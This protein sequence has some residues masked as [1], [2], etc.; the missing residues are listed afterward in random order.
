MLR[1]LCCK[2][3]AKAGSREHEVFVHWNLFKQLVQNLGFAGD[4]GDD[5]PALLEA[6]F[7]AKWSH[8]PAA[9]VR[10][11]VSPAIAHLIRER[12]WHP[13]QTIRERRDRS[14]ILEMQVNTFRELTS[15]I[16]SWGP[17]MEVLEPINL[18]ERVAQTLKA[19]AAVY[20]NQSSHTSK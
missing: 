11:R 17:D 4:D 1:K 13:S 15:W 8:G 3:S 20:E 7:G 12:E 14:L 10:I 9:R 5:I 18:R 2:I 16:C 6:G 19:A